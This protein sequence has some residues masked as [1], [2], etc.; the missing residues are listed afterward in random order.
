[1]F[2][3][4]AWPCAHFNFRIYFRLFLYSNLLVKTLWSLVKICEIFFATFKKFQAILEILKFINL[5]SRCTPEGERWFLVVYECRHSFAQYSYFGKLFSLGFPK[6]GSPQKS[7][8]FEKK[9]K[10]IITFYWGLLDNFRYIFW[11]LK[12]SCFWAYNRISSVGAI[13]ILRN[14]LNGLTF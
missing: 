9:L 5:S 11:S 2:W 6:S 4:C 12:I 8:D 3:I 7:G 13:Y 10:I 1:M 14:T